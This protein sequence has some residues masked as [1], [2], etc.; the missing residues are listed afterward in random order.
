[1]GCNGGDSYEAF[2]WIKNNYIT[3]E[4]C[5]P[6]QARGYDSGLRCIEKGVCKN[7]NEDGECWGEKEGKIY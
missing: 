6:Y 1:L 2:D 5:S 7:C 3:D 4:T